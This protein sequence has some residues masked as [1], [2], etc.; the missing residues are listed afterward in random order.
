MSRA[1][2]LRWSPCDSQIDANEL[3]LRATRLGPTQ[4]KAMRIK[5]N[6]NVD[7]GDDQANEQKLK[8]VLRANYPRIPIKHAYINGKDRYGQK[9]MTGFYYCSIKSIIQSILINPSKAGLLSFDFQFKRFQDVL[10]YSSLRAH[11][12]DRLFMISEEG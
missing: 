2:K 6:R 3:F 10:K 9:C 11:V 8:A 7:S 1:E 5:V 4:L 12:K